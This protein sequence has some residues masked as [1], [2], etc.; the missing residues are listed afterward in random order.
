MPV[1]DAI[2]DTDPRFGHLSEWREQVQPSSWENP[3]GTGTYNMVVIGAGPAGLI[4]AAGAAGLGARVALI[5]RHQMGGDCLN[6]GCVPS[7][8]VI[9]AARAVY[10][11][12]HAHR[13]GIEGAEKASANFA[14]VMERMYQ[15]RSAMSHHDSPERFS[16]L[17]VDVFLGDGKFTGPNTVS[18]GDK[19]LTFKSAV[20]ATGARA[21]LPAVPGLAECNPY[22]NEDI[23]DIPALPKRLGII[24]TGPIGVELGQSFARF[25]AQVTMIEKEDRIM[26]REEAKAAEIVTRALIEDGVNVVTCVQQ[27]QVADHG[28]HKTITYRCKEGEE[29]VI[30]V[31]EI[32]VAAGRA[33]NVNGMGLEAAGVDYDERSGIKVDANLRTSNKAIFAA[34][35]VCYPYKFTH[36]ADACA[37]IVIA[38]ALFKGRQKVTGLMMPW[39]TFTQPEVAHV[40][41]TEAEISSQNLNVDIIEVATADND[42]SKLD[43]DDAGYARVY[44]KK[45]TDQILGATLVSDHAGD[46]IGEMVLAA[47][48]G[49]GLKKIASTIHPYPTNGEIW[50]KV[51][52]TYNRGR[53]TPGVKKWMGRWLAWNR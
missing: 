43:A 9:R 5:E 31:D 24:G 48:H 19:V 46:M 32:L 44:L 49:I 35:D 7:K 26:V 30:E 38:N 51:G 6:V 41:I 42:R 2:S 33:P 15:V 1:R 3:E 25:G 39:V 18:V 14:K 4:C 12:S 28:S 17:G 16:G 50:K 34:G 23:F 47:T 29:Q 22:T 37:R 45:G 21:I 27:Q 13:F 52:D 8:G 20:I 10:E 11:A 36:A 40:G 53:L